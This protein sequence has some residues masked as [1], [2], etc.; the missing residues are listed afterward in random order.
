[1][2]ITQGRSALD[3]GRENGCNGE[4]KTQGQNGSLSAIKQLISSLGAVNKH[5]EA[6][7]ESDNAREEANQAL[8]S[9]QNLEVFEFSRSNM[10]GM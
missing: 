7:F 5:F 9:A 8:L 10:H 6:Y 2:V 4:R 3:G 1:M